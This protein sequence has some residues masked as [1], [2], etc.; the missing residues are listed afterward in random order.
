LFIGRYDIDGHVRYAAVDAAAGTLQP[1]SDPF[2]GDPTDE[3]GPVAL[4]DAVLLAPCS[5][6]T[7]VAAAVNYM[8][9]AIKRSPTDKPE[10]F[11]KPA[12]SV[13]GP[14]QPV[15]LPADAGRVEAEGE[16]VAVIGR[17]TRNVSAREAPEHVLGYT[18]G[19]DVSAREWQR[20][21]R[22][23]WRAKGCDTFSPIGPLIATEPDLRQM[24]LVTKINGVTRQE[25]SV[26]ELLFD[27]AEL[28]SFA[29][30]HL[31]L[32]PGDIVFT[33][34]PGTTPQIVPGDVI[35]VTISGV[36]SLVNPVSEAGP[37]T[38]GGSAVQEKE[39]A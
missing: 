6:K 25:T 29:S 23:F 8:S 30:R 1:I 9:H 15:L 33:G 27:V 22:Q 21:D 24:T 11:F 20:S 17:T 5:P 4:A 7:I 13:I 35:D 32:Q 26:S 3:G 18:C 37:P 2:L 12:S 28:I 36:G 19:V 16:L 34:T 10:L 38:A 14:G 39:D 31:T